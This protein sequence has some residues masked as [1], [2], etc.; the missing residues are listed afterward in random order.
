MLSQ[1]RQL[2]ILLRRAERTAFG[3][4]HD[5]VRLRTVEDYQRA[6]PLRRYDHFWTEYW[7]TRYPVL[8]NV[9]WPGLIPFFANSSG[10]S[11]GVTKHIPVTSA[12]VR[13]NRRAAI[14]L[15]VHHIANR[16]DS[17]ILGGKNFFLG[18]SAELTAVGPDVLE[19]DLSGIAAAQVPLWA[20]GFYFPNGADAKIADWEE[21][22]R[23]L[24][25]A[26]LGEDIRSFSG[27]PSWA[28]LF[29]DEMKRQAPERS[30]R[31]AEY[32]PNLEMLVH[33]G[34]S[35]APY[36]DRFAE[37][38]EGSRAET[39]E[40]YPASEGFIALQDKGPGEGLRML[41]DNGIFFEFVPVEELDA[42]EPTRHWLGNAET[43][44]NYALV[45]TTN[46]GLWSYILGDTVRLIETHPPRLLVT[47][48]TT[49]GLSA[50]GEHL[51]GE[52]IDAAVAEAARACGLLISD[53]MVGPVFAPRGPGHH[54]WLI[55]A[56]S[57]PQ[58]DTAQNFANALDADLTRRN[59]DYG[60]HRA[61][62]FGMDAPEVVFVRQGGFADWMKARGKFGGQNKVPRVIAD[63]EK[64]QDAVKALTA[65]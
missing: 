12:M 65:D 28:L 54:L 53:F 22:S 48:R 10:T 57:P 64:F 17:R 39:R 59:V 6:V 52:E 44:V 11:S 23:V 60:E 58:P 61:G 37:L 33:G 25:K 46:A 4:A 20:K 45:L 13:S 3:A 47:G 51:I 36:R 16:P 32:W 8:D 26:A 34:V 27:T 19:G 14:D 50:F 43:G 63:A 9:S 31:L 29:L 55:E 38:L 30:Q 5:F 24:A 1:R 2:N 62:G 21:K 7:G 40:V 18:G 35:F 56:V 49:Y 41:T 15:L 42:P